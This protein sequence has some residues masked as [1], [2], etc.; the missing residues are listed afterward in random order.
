MYKGFGVLEF[1]LLVDKWI[2]SVSDMCVE[3]SMFLLEKNGFEVVLF[4]FDFEVFEDD[5][6]I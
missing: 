4:L 1:I 5:E 3:K 6:V 2:I